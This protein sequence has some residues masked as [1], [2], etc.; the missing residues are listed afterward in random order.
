MSERLRIRLFSA[1]ELDSDVER[2]K[3]WGDFW[4]KEDF[5]QAFEE[6]GHQ[7][8]HERP[9]L[10]LHLF[11]YPLQE[12]PG[13]TYKIIWIM[14]HPDWITPGVLHQYDK[15]YCNAVK[16]TRKL[17]RCGIEAEALIGATSLSPPPEIEPQ[18]QV[19]FV[20]NSRGDSGRPCVNAL[21]DTGCS[22]KVW[23]E[24]WDSILR[25]DQLV[26]L[27]VDHNLTSEIYAS[28]IISINDHHADMREY[29][30]VNPRL[31][32]VLASGGFAISDDNTAIQEI[33][34]DSVPVFRNDSELREIV[35]YYLNHPEE[36]LPLMAKG[37]EIAVKYSFSHL[38]QRI[39]NHAVAAV[40]ERE[41]RPIKPNR[42]NG[43]PDSSPSVLPDCFF[44]YSAEMVG[45]VWNGD[46]DRVT[47]LRLERTTGRNAFICDIIA[48][49]ESGP[50]VALQGIGIAPVAGAPHSF[51]VT[52]PLYMLGLSDEAKNT[53]REITTN[54]LVHLQKNPSLSTNPIIT[55]NLAGRELPEEINF[56][57]ERVIPGT[58]RYQLYV[59]HV[60]RYLTTVSTLAGKTVLDAGCGTGYGSAILSRYAKRVT[61]I[62]IAP[63]AV[64]F[65]KG[66]YPF[67]N[68]AFGL[69][70]VRKLPFSDNTFE[71][72]VS[73]E[74]M[75]HLKRYDLP[76]YLH[77]MRRV[78]TEGGCC[79][80]ST[81]NKILSG[82][83]ANEFHHSEMYLDEFIA[84]IRE[85]FKP[86]ALEVFGQKQWRG[87]LR[88]QHECEVNER[89]VDH[90]NDYVFIAKCFT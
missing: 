85:D 18:Y 65:A 79:F 20:G 46:L 39:I 10:F 25:K 28:A 14:S 42:S 80:I 17:T 86:R 15:I 72:V 49:R 54:A 11:G 44:P 69:G 32:D 7:V 4:V 37:R 84:T 75:E 26:A 78:L 70:D 8:V 60:Q 21:R 22:L 89:A 64:A 30:F 5:K 31:F 58:T 23:G 66:A 1:D 77:E 3:R 57:G 6:L 47:A 41:R 27:S 81:P 48:Q 83:L 74:V 36:R 68:L 52:L 55:F 2:R 16:F 45:D 19:V 9:N 29:G 88:L 13:E 61:G 43:K 63:E 71:C 53:I 59:S 73:F 62:D 50:Y 56:T 67:T 90:V 51:V 40:S 35:D 82:P 34:G 24:G 33:F 87:H 12:M 76:F 38:A